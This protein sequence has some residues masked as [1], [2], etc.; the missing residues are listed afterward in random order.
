MLCGHDRLQD[1]RQRGH[2]ATWTRDSVEV[3]GL[4]SYGPNF[5]GLG[6]RAGE[7]LRSDIPVEQPTK[8]DVAGN[9]TTARALGLDVPPMLLARARVHQPRGIGAVERLTKRHLEPTLALFFFRAFHAASPISVLKQRVC[10]NSP[11]PRGGSSMETVCII[12]FRNAER[13]QVTISRY[14]IALCLA[15]HRFGCSVT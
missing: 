13:L 15:L 1:G 12:R 10:P 7:V 9:L 4:I 11:S 3:S 14:I 5:P 8:F 2:S 6:R